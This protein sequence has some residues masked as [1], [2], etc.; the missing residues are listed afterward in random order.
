[1]LL[2]DEQF[3]ERTHFSDY[4][5]VD[6]A[7][8]T[9]LTKNS[10]G[11]SYCELCKKK[12]TRKKEGIVLS[13]NVFF[14]RGLQTYCRFTLSTIKLFSV[15][16]KYSCESAS[17]QSP[18]MRHQQLLLLLTRSTPDVEQKRSTKTPS[19]FTYLVLFLSD[20]SCNVNGRKYCAKKSLVH[21]TD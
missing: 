10:V 5:S 4:N 19:S 9:N 17:R 1:M 12:R 11:I 14:L 6:F 7:T 2:E 16:V 20:F 18:C 3:T 8:T 21:S 15:F 13:V